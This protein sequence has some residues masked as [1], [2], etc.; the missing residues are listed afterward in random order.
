MS[1]KTLLMYF[2]I[3]ALLLGLNTFVLAKQSIPLDSI[4]KSIINTFLLPYASNWLVST[5]APTEI[6]GDRSSLIDGKPV[7]E[8]TRDSVKKVIGESKYGWA[9][10]S[11]TATAEQANIPLWV[12]YRGYSAANIWL[13]GVLVHTVGNVSSH[14]KDE[15]LNRILVSESSKVELAEG[16]NYLLVEFSYVSLVEQV[17]V[18]GSNPHVYFFVLFSPTDRSRNQTLQAFFYGASLFTLLILIVTHGYLSIKSIHR[19]HRYATFS[20]LFLLIHLLNPT[21]ETMVGLTNNH[22]VL[23]EI[24]RIF[25]FIFALYYLFIAIRSFYKLPIPYFKLQMGVLLSTLV[26]LYALFF[27]ITLVFWLHASIFIIALSYAIYTLYQKVTTSDYREVYGLII[28]LFITLMGAFSYILAHWFVCCNGEVLHLMAVTCVYIGMPM[29]FLVSISQ[30]F[31]RTFHSIEEQVKDRTKELE[32]R[33]GFKTRFLANI[34]HELRTPVTILNGLI[35]KTISKKK[36]DSNIEI[37]VQEAT[38]INRNLDR[39]STLVSQIVDISKSDA[40]DIDLN[41]KVFS[42]VDIIKNSIQ[43]TNSILE[44]KQQRV[45]LLSEHS[46]ILLKVD[47]EKILTIVNNLLT[48]AAKFSPANSVITIETRIDQDHNHFEIDVVDQGVGVKQ[49][50]EELIFERF[51]RLKQTNT[52]YVEGMGIGLELSRNFA[53]KHG[54]DIKV[55]Q[56]NAPGARFRV[57]L[58]Y[59]EH[60]TLAQLPNSL[61]SVTRPASSVVLDSKPKNGASG[62]L[63]HILLVEDNPD[64]Q[65]FVSGLLQ[66]VGLVSVSADGHKALEVLAKEHI[67]LVVTDLMM[68][69]MTGEQLIQKMGEDNALKSIPVIVLSAKHMEENR[70]NLL[71]VGVIDYITK[72]FNSEELLLKISNLV[73]LSGVRKNAKITIP[74]DKIEFS[75]DVSESA[76]TFVLSKIDD[77]NLTSSDLASHF[78][79]SERS[80]YRK[81]ERETGLTPAAFIR[82]VRLQYAARLME[83]S[84]DVRLNEMADKVGYKSAGSFKKAYQNRFGGFPS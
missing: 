80:L 3:C 32:E 47:G 19:Y 76:K 14:P 18:I 50:D 65:E 21:L 44:T 82:E 35:T 1:V 73:K 25:V 20:N 8:L 52:D 39:L 15:I 77:A 71:R 83:V 10:L 66:D 70:L 78:L 2:Y 81:L 63:P 23:F 61:T 37:T 48:N 79:M 40:H 55:I 58:P 4:P 36:Q 38:L 56:Q 69:N 27:N 7:Y 45:Q 60:V 17:N 84:K 43:L 54:G 30:N 31:A 59:E 62:T 13:N 53:R 26:G 75:T 68:P 6:H 11:F 51:Y 33:D 9:E 74:D 28:G 5:S 46:N 22:I 29:S 64:M 42:I 57:T 34:S 16:D 72:P 12:K 41:L 67:D 24:N 49:S